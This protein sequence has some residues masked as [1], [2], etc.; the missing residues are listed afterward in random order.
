MMG[1]K[2]LKNGIPWLDTDGNIIH[3]HGGHILKFNGKYFWYGENREDNIYV[4]CC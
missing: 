2:V 4:S 1:K 3:A